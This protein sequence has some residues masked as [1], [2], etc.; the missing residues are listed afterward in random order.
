MTYMSGKMR[1]IQMLEFYEEKEWE[2]DREDLRGWSEDR[3]GGKADNVYTGRF[4]LGMGTWRRW[5]EWCQGGATLTLGFV[6]LS[7]HSI[8]SSYSVFAHAPEIFFTHTS[9][10]TLLV[11]P[12]L[13][14]INY[15]F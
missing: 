13:S 10:T 9:Q 2:K 3:C 8:K 6:M 15:C 5:V 12:F 1:G 4:C 11:V 14:S 7:L